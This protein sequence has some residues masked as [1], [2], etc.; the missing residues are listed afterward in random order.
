MKAYYI[1]WNYSSSADDSLYYG[2]Q[3][4]DKLFHHKENA[5]KYMEEKLK[6]FFGVKG[7]A[8]ILFN[9]E[10][11]GTITKEESKELKEL[12][13]SLWYEF[14]DSPCEGVVCERDIIF[15]DKI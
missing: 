15:E 12:C 8:E 5:E 11:N 4:D 9:K 10:K 6:D 7:R 14:A 13:E 3:D 2:G 1:H